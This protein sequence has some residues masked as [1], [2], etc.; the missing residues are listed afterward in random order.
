L[1]CND[2]T[3]LLEAICHK[4]RK[5]RERKR[6]YTSISP[7]ARGTRKRTRVDTSPKT[8]RKR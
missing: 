8:R 3:K 2:T 7:H 4:K 1:S 5:P 6:A